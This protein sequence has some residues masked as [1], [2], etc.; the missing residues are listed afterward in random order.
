MKNWLRL[1]VCLLCLL[2]AKNQGW[3]LKAHENITAYAIYQLP[4][5]LYPFYRTFLAEIRN[6]STN[7]DKRRRLVKGE[8]AH[9][10]ISCEY[11][12][13]ASDQLKERLMLK[14]DSA[15]KV[16]DLEHLNQLGDLPWHLRTLEYRLT[17]AFEQKKAQE[18]IK[19]SADIA[20]Y[21]ADAAVPLHTTKNYNGQLTGQQGIHA[22][23]E[24]T[25][26]SQIKS[27]VPPG[28][29]KA[30]YNNNLTELIADIIV[31]SYDKAD[32]VL[33]FDRLTKMKVPKDEWY[34]PAIKKNNNQAT[35]YSQAYIT[36]FNQYNHQMVQG[37]MTRASQAISTFW[38]SCWVNAGKPNIVPV[39]TSPLPPNFMDVAVSDQVNS[40]FEECGE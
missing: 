31:E 7:P 3:G 12:T 17:T 23:W 2:P 28:F 10:F 39:K 27:P 35:V 14:Y 29:K 11:L 34:A 8:S 21:I 40:P 1:T 5:E 26:A 36:L 30:G 4:A 32:S 22:L 18:I 19:L 6:A 20:H 24:T 15:I 13:P 9:H 38:Y 37:R 25:T 16:A 33:R